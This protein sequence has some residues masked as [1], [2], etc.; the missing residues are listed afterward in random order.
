MKQVAAAVAEL[1]AHGWI[2]KAK[3]AAQVDGIAKKLD[4]Q[5]Q[6][7]S[8]LVDGL[9][10]CQRVVSADIERPHVNSFATVPQARG[11]SLYFD[12]YR[13]LLFRQ[14]FPEANS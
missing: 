14:I 4:E 1:D 2:E 13:G 11:V 3:Q 12:H 7:L 9:K 8:S 10:V 6:K 5:I